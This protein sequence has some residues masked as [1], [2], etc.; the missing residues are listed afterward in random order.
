[1]LLLQRSC[2]HK[3]TVGWSHFRDLSSAVIQK[4]ETFRSDRSHNWQCDSHA[5]WQHRFGKLCLKFRGS[6]LWLIF[7]VFF[8]KCTDLHDRI[9]HDILPGRMLFNTPRMYMNILK[10]FEYISYICYMSV[11]ELTKSWN[12]CISLHFISFHVHGPSDNF[13]SVKVQRKHHSGH[14]AWAEVPRSSQIDVS[15]SVG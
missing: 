12:I 13:V 4:R 7:D 6:W 3:V 11:K 14:K 15:H 9:L 10:Y 8:S 5:V 1:M 2:E